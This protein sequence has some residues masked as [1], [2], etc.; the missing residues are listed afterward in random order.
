MIENISKEK[1]LESISSQNEYSVR[2]ENLFD[3]LRLPVD[4]SAELCEY[5]LSDGGSV[6]AIVS[7]P[8]LRV[9]RAYS[10]VYNSFERN[11]TK[12]RGGGGCPLVE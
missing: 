4:G 9:F 8:Q 1:Q 3:H 10:D 5:S 6:Y 11:F 7:H 12:L 2:E